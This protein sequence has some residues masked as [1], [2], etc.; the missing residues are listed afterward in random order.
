MSDK[1]KDRSAFASCGHGGVIS[2]DPLFRLWVPFPEMFGSHSLPTYLALKA[3]GRWCMLFV[4]ILWS[5]HL[6]PRMC[7]M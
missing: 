7:T 5:K 6:W 3:S 2:E 1:S 4:S